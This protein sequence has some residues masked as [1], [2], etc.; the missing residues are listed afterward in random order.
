MKMS[1]AKE[2]CV[3]GD[4]TRPHIC[5]AHLDV[6]NKALIATNGHLLAMVPVDVQDGDL[7]GPVP[8]S[9]LKHAR[10]LAKRDSTLV[11]QA[12]EREVRAVD[13]SGTLRDRSANQF[14]PYANVLTSYPE[15]GEGFVTVALDAALLWDLA[16]ALGC[17]RKD[18]A[19]VLLTFPQDT[20]QLGPIQVRRC[21][22]KHL[23][24]G[25]RGVLMPVRRPP[26]QAPKS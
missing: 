16:Q 18:D 2:L 26:E 24:D 6:E 22:P 14:P 19:T 20:K 9:A 25:S 21:E 10:K 8:V 15:S 1:K 17:A 12:A 3:S 7:A 4:A 13:G 23:A 5:Q 11:L